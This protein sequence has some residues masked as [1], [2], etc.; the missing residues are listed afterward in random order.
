MRSSEDEDDARNDN[1][2]GDEG[3]REVSCRES[4]GASAR[5]G[6]V[7]GRVRKAIERHGGGAGSEHGHDDP[8]KLMT[9]GKAR[10]GEHSSAE[11]E[12]E[13]EDGVLPLD[14]LKRHAKIVSDSH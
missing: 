9:G 7:D 13:S 3:W 2:S 10:S 11:S 6:R 5:V 12:W 8:E 14:H 4:P 1:E